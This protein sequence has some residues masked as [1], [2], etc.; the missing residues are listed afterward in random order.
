MT[1]FDNR[2]DAWLAE[3][4]DDLIGYILQR[5]ADK[6]AAIQ[7]FR[8]H[9]KRSPETI[10]SICHGMP[11]ANYRASLGYVSMGWYHGPWSF[12]TEEEWRAVAKLINDECLAEV[13]ARYENGG[14]C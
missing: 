2:F 1:I 11:I 6:Q 4:W 3:K 7:E 10:R 13:Q 8:E 9:M 5:I 14:G 12:E